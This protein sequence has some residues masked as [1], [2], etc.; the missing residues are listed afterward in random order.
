MHP[1]SL[2]RI[3]TKLASSST[4]QRAQRTKKIKKMA[5]VLRLL[6]VLLLAAAAASDAVTIVVTNKCAYTVWPA[7]LPGGGGAQLNTGDSWSIDVAPETSGSVWGRTGCG[8][9]T[10]NGTQLGQCQT[11][12]CGGTL[13]CSKLGFSPLTLAEFTLGSH[14]GT[15][16]FDISLVHGFNAPMSFLPA[17]GGRCARGGPSCPVQEITFDC[18]SDQRATAGCNNPCDGKSGCGPNNGTEYFKKACP[19]TVT[20][21]GDTDNTTYTC[22]SGT[23]Y[24]ITCLNL[25]TNS[26]KKFSR[27]QMLTSQHPTPTNTHPSPY[28]PPHTSSYYK[29]Y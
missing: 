1:N 23:N 24:Q 6:A 22:T 21:V 4:L 16:Y 2:R 13:A 19:E 12:D 15:D 11:G 7:A 25:S 27:M 3:T 9:I 29:L 28:I 17:A 8:F 26:W 18:P 5:S 20:Y 10:N 14:G